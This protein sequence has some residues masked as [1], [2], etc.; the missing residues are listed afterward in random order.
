MATILPTGYYLANFRQLLD[1][2]A[3]RYW[4]LLSSAEQ[5]YYQQFIDLPATSQMLYIRLLSRR[6]ENFLESKLNYPEIGDIPAA[7]NTLC[8]RELLT[9]HS[10]LSLEQL[11]PLFNKAHIVK[12]LAL[13]KQARLS[14]G[15]LDQH[16]VSNA[17]SS[18]G[19]LLLG[20]DRVFSISGQNFF[21]SFQ[22]CFFGNLHQDLTD[23]VLRDL[24]LQQYEDYTIEKASLPFLQRAQ[25]ERHLEYY[26]CN[27]EAENTLA[28][29]ASAI[30]DL[31][32]SLPA[33]D[34][35][36]P[37]LNRR[38]QRLANT[39]ARQ[40][41][42]LGAAQQA[43]DIYR[44]LDRPPARERRARILA[45]T[46]DIE[47]SL[48]LCDD[49]ARCAHNEEER[50]FAL[51]FA[52]RLSRKH[53]MERTRPSSYRPP[54]KKLELPA[55]D[56]PVELAVAKQHQSNGS[57]FYVENSL[58]NGVL[59]LAIWD[60]VFAP[61]AGAFYNPFQYAPADFYEPAFIERR[62]QALQ[63]RLQCL[64][65]STFFTELVL[66]TFH[67]KSGIANPLVH[68]PDLNP[69]LLQLALQRI[70][71][72][73]W[74]AMLQRLLSDLRNHRNGM[75]DLILF[76]DSGGYQWI[77]VKGPGDRLQKNQLRWL[78]FFAEQ[79]I[80]H[81]LIYVEWQDPS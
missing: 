10:E 11:L 13:S 37:I 66:H 43:M 18:T 58:V 16:V 59:G 70:P 3:D 28:Q 7:A 40:L 29:D 60:I 34:P 42:R 33:T 45:T 6:A 31:W 36:D 77:E 81:Q 56:Q 9:V 73:H 47:A 72:V 8:E 39:L 5:R 69:E 78:A 12:T 54:E 79:G 61:V 65:D 51:Q 30:V 2:V 32:Q 55:S 48:A 74:Q 15:E 19:A 20:A 17:D 63:S 26:R 76:P 14:R 38:I 67:E 35:E 46:G 53:G 1:F 62:Q 25:I 50:E 23:F 64:T 22:L 68:W 27:Q 75:P 44:Q 49:I 24:G 21:T 71:G 57:C 80:P 52:Y 4:Q 41:E